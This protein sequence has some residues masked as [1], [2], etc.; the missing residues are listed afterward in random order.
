MSMKKLVSA[1]FALTLLMLS[2]D[3]D[4]TTSTTTSTYDASA[5]LS[6]WTYN[7]IIPDYTE[8]VTY[9]QA[10]IEAKDTFVNDAT[11]V[12]LVLLRQAYID[13]YTNF[14]HIGAYGVGLADTSNYYLYINTF[15]TDS[16]EIE[17]NI[18]A[19]FT[20][21][22]L[23]S[24]FQQPTQGFP[25]IDYLLNGIASS[26]AEI[27]TALT[28]SHLDYLSIVVDKID[29]RTDTILADW[30]TSYASTFVANSGSDITSSPNKFYNALVFYFENYVRRQKIDIPAG[31]FT[32]DT[33]S[34][35]IESVYDAEES[36]DLL[37]AAFDKF[38]DFYL[39]SDEDTA[40]LSSVL[41]S[42]GRSD[43]DTAIKAQFGV[44]ATAI[45]ALDANLGSQ[46]DTDNLL[47]LTARDEIQKIVAYLKVDVASALDFSITFVD[48]D[49]D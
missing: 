45:D 30:N 17:S 12:N 41:V 34:G 6:S 13:A 32:S 24:V 31:V 14:Q 22:D 5:L 21:S 36:K 19:G 2:C 33:F 3:S 20:S 16:E 48:N 23:D 38:E 25:A 29:S 28:D 8:F 46:I 7:H 26:D 43:L 40:S 49:G 10:L 27:I 1:L 9:T 37:I 44:A 11:E 42:V 18:T 4:E 35:S 39:G 15:P 47:M